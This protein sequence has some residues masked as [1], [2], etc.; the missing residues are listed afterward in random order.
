MG[1]RPEPLRF[2]QAFRA[3]FL[4]LMAGQV[5]TDL[6]PDVATGLILLFAAAL[7]RTMVELYTRPRVTPVAAPQTTDGTPLVP[8]VIP[9]PEPATPKP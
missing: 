1:D 4:V 2:Y 9:P 3:G 8:L 5:F 6:I 7:D